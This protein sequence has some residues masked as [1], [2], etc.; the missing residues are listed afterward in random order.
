MFASY[1]N[2]ILLFSLYRRYAAFIPANPKR[3]QF[4]RYANSALEKQGRGGLVCTLSENMC[5]AILVEKINA[6]LKSDN[7]VSQIGTT[8]I[9]KTNSDREENVF[10]LSE[11]V[12]LQF[13]LTFKMFVTVNNT[14]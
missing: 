7:Y 11:E 8:V 4:V 6:F 10:V 9:G 13:D 2:G 12:R 14:G 5:K 1:S 3:D